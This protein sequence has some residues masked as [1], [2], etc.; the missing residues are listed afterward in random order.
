MQ[1]KF[2][3]YIFGKF[4]L[5]NAIFA[6]RKKMQLFMLTT[7]MNWACA[8]RMVDFIFENYIACV[9]SIFKNKAK[10]IYFRPAY[11]NI[12][13]FKFI[14]PFVYICIIRIPFS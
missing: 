9:K 1:I 6:L 10:N 8:V 3:K 4:Y 12:F 7:L 5:N 14:I 2:F 13:F 11:S